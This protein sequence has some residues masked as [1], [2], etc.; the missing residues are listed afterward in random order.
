MLFI[1]VPIIIIYDLPY[2]LLAN[3]PEPL[4]ISNIIN[5]L[6]I[7]NKQSIIRLIYAEHLSKQLCKAI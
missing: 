1:Y 4:H 5:M 6:S 7:Q 2:E 3:F